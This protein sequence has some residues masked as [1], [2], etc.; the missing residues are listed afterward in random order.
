M[1]KLLVQ[2]QMFNRHYSFV[3][4]SM[5]V[6]QIS[7]HCF[8]EFLGI[9]KFQVLISESTWNVKWAAILFR[10]NPVSEFS[11][12]ISFILLWV[13]MFYNSS[14]KKKTYFVYNLRIITFVLLNSFF[15]PIFRQNS[16]IFLSNILSIVL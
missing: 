16:H 5:V 3:F 10:I 9:Y 8:Y 11:Y 15:K 13:L 7:F 4:G 14:Y 2:T 6:L 1:W 12:L